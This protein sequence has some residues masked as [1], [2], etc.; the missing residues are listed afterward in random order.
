[1]KETDLALLLSRTVL[2]FRPRKIEKARAL[3]SVT[4]ATA[5]NVAHYYGASWACGSAVVVAVVVSRLGNAPGKKFSLRASIFTLLGF[6]AALTVLSGVVVT[7]V[8]K[9]DHTD[10]DNSGS[11]TPDEIEF[12]GFASPHVM[13][14]IE[15]FM[16]GIYS[17]FP[18]VLVSSIGLPL[19]DL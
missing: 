12:V 17:L 1:M 19:R 16:Q 3:V 18:G 9:M 10:S 6:V 13:R 4:A 5:L 7:I 15:P 14:F 8:L 2:H 11:Q